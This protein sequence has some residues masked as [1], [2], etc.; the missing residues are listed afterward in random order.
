MH[1]TEKRK[2]N[3]KK[4]KSRYS[5]LFPEITALTPPGQHQKASF[6]KSEASKKGIVHK[7]RRCP[8]IDLRF[9]P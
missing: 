1:T 6:S 4:E 5:D 9:S 7:L 2:K 8:I 3:Y